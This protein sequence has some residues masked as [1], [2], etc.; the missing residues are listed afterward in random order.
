M[1]LLNENKYDEMCEILLNLQKLYCPTITSPADESGSDHRRFQILLDG[2]Q[3]TASRARGSIRL[4]ETH[5]PNER[6]DG[7]L[8]CI[9]DWHSR[10]T[11]VA[12]SACTN[13]LCYM[14]TCTIGNK[15]KRI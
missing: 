12:V 9:T 13:Y 7:F 10:M 2:D 8:P 3:L 4:R 14:Y 1:Q 6:I 11:L 5:E 15:Q